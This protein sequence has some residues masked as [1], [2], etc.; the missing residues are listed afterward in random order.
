MKAHVLL[1][2]ERVDELQRLLG[3]RSRT[4]AVAVAVEEQI[5]REKLKRLGD[6]FGTIDIDETAL[7]S[8]EAAEV[9]EAAGPGVDSAR[10]RGRR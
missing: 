6:L 4:A 3:A 2:S 10:R 1:K 9:G 5:R 8:I 7:E